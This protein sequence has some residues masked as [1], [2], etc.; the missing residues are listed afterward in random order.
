MTTINNSK[1]VAE[2]STSDVLV[3][4]QKLETF[5]NEENFIPAVA[6][7]RSKVLLALL[8]KSL[9][10]GRAVCALVEAGFDSEA[11]GLSRTLIDIFL[12]VRYITNKDTEARARQYAEYVAKTQEELIRLS[13][14][15][16]PAKEVHP[17]LDD[18]FAALAR[19]YNSAHRWT[20]ARIS[21][22]ALEPDSYEVDDKGRPTIHDFDYEFV[23]WQTSQFVHA[24][25]LSLVGHAT[26]QR[27]PFRI[28]ANI[29]QD[30][31]RGDEALFNALA[32]ISKT[33]VSG[34]RGLQSDQPADILEETRLLLSSYAKFLPRRQQ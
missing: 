13:H 2:P 19:N 21:E 1:G 12:N 28:R 9:T 27:E 31:G 4:I 29:N 33:F 18:E 3:L 6:F 7:Y 23:Y 10:T 20:E 8:S 11:F 34:F 32:F 14:K 24:T 17:E 22:M 25:I 15:H 30:V 5:I 26:S 16:F